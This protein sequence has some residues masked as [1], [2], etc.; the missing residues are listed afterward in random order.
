[1]VT[2]PLPCFNILFI[3]NDA[4]SQVIGHVCYHILAP[5]LNG[6]METIT[7][8]N[9]PVNKW[10]CDVAPILTMM[11]VKRLSQNPNSLAIGKPAIH[12]ATVDLKGKAYELLRQN[13]TRF[14][15]DDVYRNP[16]P[17]QF[18]GSGADA[19]A[20][21]HMKTMITWA[22]SRNYMNISTR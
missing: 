18:D 16:G 1:M 8:L 9:N 14:L 10:H 22:A 4:F 15:L 6:Y 20:V 7:N 19:K 21:T 13:A 3:N 11:I 2:F 5:C 17:L 12:L